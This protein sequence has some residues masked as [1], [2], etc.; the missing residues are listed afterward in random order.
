MNP[1]LEGIIPAVVTPL[2]A[3]GEFRADSFQQLLDRT[4]DAGTAGVYV[5]GN[6]GEGP[7]L[8]LAA[9][10]AAA[11]AAV[12]YSPAGKTVIVHTGAASTR[13]AIDLTR[14]AAEVGAHAV[15]SMPP[16]QYYS[17]EEILAYYR[18]IASASPLPVLVYYIPVISQTT[19]S[20]EQIF[21]LCAIDNVAGLKF[22][23]S[24][25]YKMS[26]I[27]RAGRVIFNGSDEILAAGL[28]MGASGGI[29]TF[30]CLVPELF[31]EIYQH[32]RAGRYQ[33][34]RQVQDHVNDLVRAVLGFPALSA[35][36]LLLK[37]SGIDCGATVRPRRALT[38]DEESR[39]RIAVRQAGF[40][41]DGFLKP[42]AAARHR[43]DSGRPPSNL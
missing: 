2:D 15:S 10:K 20:L 16:S 40:E 23:D 25:L 14:H 18:E 31:V 35:V 7:Q 26:M 12:R 27:S 28:L 36:K 34:A 30:Y 32:S 21:E 33:Q 37:W 42:R 6:T 9:R 19:R 22:T 1:V 38:A 3:A 13:D 17:F 5:C 8:H 11:E 4:Y 24:D 29:G 39:L 41:P 43:G